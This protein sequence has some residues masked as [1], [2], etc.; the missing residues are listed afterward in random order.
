MDDDA[1]P[2]QRRQWL[3]VGVAA[4][5][6]AGALVGGLALTNHAPAQATAKPVSIAV[7]AQQ[8]AKPKAK[9]AAGPTLPA[10]AAAIVYRLTQLLPA[11][12]TSGYGR[13]SD[14]SL[15]GQIDLDRG[16]GSGML[17]LNISNRIDSAKTA[18]S[19]RPTVT[20]TR[21]PGNCIQSLVVNVVRS[22][23][24]DVQLNVA[25]CLAWNGHANPPGPA[26]LTEQ[27]AIKIATDP[28]WGTRMD[29]GLVTAAAQRFPN[30]PT[31]S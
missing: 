17:R 16:H 10:T 13:A 26:P 12:T 15:F 18:Q 6:V 14:G 28:S 27:E 3:T 24:V 4:V 21:I 25:T 29:A 23:G 19:D 2:K 22:D 7:A 5:A 11:G 8:A 1:R 9:Q 20:V 30:L 31:F